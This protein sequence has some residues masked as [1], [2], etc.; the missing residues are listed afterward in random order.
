[1]VVVFVWNEQRNRVYHAYMVG[2][3][4]IRYSIYVSLWWAAALL[5]PA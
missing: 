2:S 3:V 1:M 4:V 5:S